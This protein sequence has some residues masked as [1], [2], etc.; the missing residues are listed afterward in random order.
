[1]NKKIHVGIWGLGRA[2][3]NMHV[4]EI[5]QYP[6][7][8][9]IVAGCD[10]AEDRRQ[11]MAAKCRC[12][13]YA[14][15]AAF[16][17]DPDVD[18]VSVATRSTDH[19]L[20]AC[21]ALQA[22]KY[23]FLEKPIALNGTE[24]R[25]LIAADRQFPGR[26]YLRYNRHFEPPFVHIREIIATGVLGEI[27]EVKLHRH[28]FQRR[29]DWQ[30]LIACGGGQLNNWGPHIIEHALCFL[31]SP[32]A[33]IWSDLK[34]IAAVG[35]AEDHLKI[36]L[37]GKNGR[38]VD[39]E[40]SGGTALS[41]P[42]YII[43]GAKGALNCQA[44]NI[45]LK[46]IDPQQKLADIKAHSENPPLNGGFSNEEAIR[47]IEQ[48]V[49]VT[50]KAGCDTTSIWEHLYKAIRQHVPFPITLAQGLEVVRI[51]EIVKKDTPFAAKTSG[52]SE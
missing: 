46:Y 44:D 3:N 24:T 22:G 42:E 51:A 38:I 40:I 47:W 49:K 48:D 16:L 19:V 12:R 32:V 14:D 7:L 33:E 21:Q 27:Y 18:L 30:T 6:Q 39:L 15:P 35:D 52:E 20:H 10:T 26:L 17:A 9:E 36:I 29:D 23:V 25:K 2:G 5:Q 8:F 34:R 11:A 41:Q 1:M 43:F 37:K 50:P 31:E 28:G 4:S 45:H 13:L